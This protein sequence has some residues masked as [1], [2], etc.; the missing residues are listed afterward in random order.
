MPACL[1]SSQGESCENW[2]T[3]FSSMSQGSEFETPDL[4]NATF[5]AAHCRIHSSRGRDVSR[6]GALKCPA[7]TMYGLVSQ[8][9]QSPH[10]KA[11]RVAEITYLLLRHCESTWVAFEVIRAVRSVR[12]LRQDG[13][14][15][16]RHY[17][18]QSLCH[19][20]AE[21]DVRKGFRI[22]V[23]RLS[24]NITELVIRISRND[25]TL[26][27]FHNPIPSSRI[28][29]IETLNRTRLENFFSTLSQTGLSFTSLEST[30]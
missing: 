23:S 21:P 30:G 20:G 15:N 2:Q 1:I 3:Y 27:G 25:N 10:R 14:E 5:Q 24:C 7:S 11:T 28:V 6:V 26:L 19:L 8:I 29:L 4:T 9:R 18:H 12:F 13:I 22:L 17:I 16:A